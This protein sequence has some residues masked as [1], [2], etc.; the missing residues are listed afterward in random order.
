MDFKDWL[1]VFLPSVVLI[2]GIVIFL[3][4]KK[5][6]IQKNKCE[7]LHLSDVKKGYQYCLSC[8]KAY[9]APQKV[10]K[11]HNYKIIDSYSSKNAITGN[12]YKYT[13][14]QECQ[15]CG[16]ITVVNTNSVTINQ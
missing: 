2:V 10:C 15:N 12:V 9:L 4:P 13:Y 5:Q 6:A 14:V 8:N 3:L 1:I 11:Q 7:C 16:I